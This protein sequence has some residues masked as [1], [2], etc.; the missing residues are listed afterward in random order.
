M[1]D[2]SF[3]VTLEADGA[4]VGERRIGGIRKDK[5]MSFEWRPYHIGSHTLKVAVNPDKRMKEQNF[6]NNILE[7]DVVVVFPDLVPK[8]ITSDNIY[9]SATNK[10]TVTVSGTAECF[11]ISLVENG[12]VVGNTTNVTCYGKENVSVNWKPGSIGNH[13]ITAFVDSDDDIKETNEMNNNITKMFEVLLPDIVPEDITPE[14][15]YIDEVNTISVKVNGT[16]EGFNATLVADKMGV[17]RSGPLRY[18]IIPV[19]NGTFGTGETF[20]GNTTDSNLTYNITAQ[21]ANWSWKDIDTL[22]VS[23]ASNTSTGLIDS[24]DAW[25]VDYVAVVVNYTVN[26]TIVQTLELNANSVISSGNWSNENN[27]YITDD[28]YATATEITT[29][30]LGVADTEAVFGNI[31]SVVIKVEQYVVN[32]IIPSLKNDTIILKKTNLNT[33]NNSIKFEWL[34]TELGNYSLTVFLDSDNDVVETNETNNNLT[35]SVIVA[36]R[37]KLKL[38]SPKSGETWKG[39]RN[40]TWAATYEEPLLIDLFY[41]PD[42]RGYRWINITTN[43]TN[44]GSYAWDTEDV[45]DG[46]YMIKVVARAGV[47]T[48]EDKSDIFYIRNNDEWGSFHQNAGYAPCEAPDTNETAWVS[49]DIGAEGSSSLIVAKGKIFVYCT[50]WEGMYSD[51]TYL[52]ALDESTGEVLW[53]TKIAPREYGS[54]ATPA[55]KD[56]SVYVSS[57]KGIYRIDADTGD[58][59]WE[60]RFPTGKGSV[61]GGPAV[62]SRAVYVGDWDGCHYYGID[63]NNANEIWRFEVSG[64]AQSVPAVAYGNIYFGCYGGRDNRAYGVDAW[65]GKKIWNTSFPSTKH[66]CGSVTIAEGIVYFT[67][68]DFNGP[69]IFYALDAFNGTE[70]W[71]ASI[72]RTDSTPAY[73]P[74]RGY[75]YVAGGVTGYSAKEVSCFDAKT[76]KP[77]WKVPG[78][79]CPECPPLGSWTNSPI[80]TKDE[81]VFVGKECEKSEEMI[82]EYCGLYCLDAVTGEE[83]WHSEKGGSS[84]VVVNGFVY[85]IGE[86]K[87]IAFG[88]GTI[89]DLTVDANATD[90]RYV[91]GKKGNITAK[92]EN[93]GKSNVT[94]SFKV[95]LR[96]KG[97][98]TA[99]QTVQPPL[100]INNSR[101]VVFEWTPE[102][103][104]EHRL[105]VEVDPPPGNVTE[106][107]PWNNIANVT[108][109]VEDNKPDLIT[110]ITSVS[111]ST[112]YVGDEVT[113]EA[114]ITNIGYETSNL[115][116]VRFSVNDVEEDMTLTSLVNN[117]RFLYFT[118]NALNNGIYNLTVDANP[119]DSLTIKNEVTW[120]NNKDSRVVEVM[121]TPTPTPTLTPENPCYGPGSRGGYGGGSAGGIGEGSGIGEAGAGEAGGMQIPVNASDSADEK[122]KEVFGFPFGNASSGA[123]GGGGTLPL[124]LIALIVLTFALFY[125]GYYK[126]KRAY[127]GDKK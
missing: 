99:E 119:N 73:Y 34:T 37:I 55:Y 50:G 89:P 111:P 31:T 69:G 78:P 108:V 127:R 123:S 51:Y 16:A 8:A 62:T 45:P 125:F 71:S 98:V 5:T 57:G 25:S 64:K 66:V 81:K 122:K 116:Y 101:E 4:L 92:I 117:T 7:K 38:L 18:V 83:I 20:F 46:E 36:K 70:I 22:E 19:F 58:F 43:E 14:V 118:W 21:R 100:N 76:G 74:S 30:Q 97:D 65:S 12:T 52:V 11:N 10:I 29:M 91:V 3:N 1:T 95:E 54:W 80:V 109:F 110:S 121:P 24:G 96:H 79:Q 68:F 15:L 103:P 23:I 60:F 61:N 67:T 9:M 84:P 17:D 88:N 72:E 75:V 107:N 49:D 106:S 82:P 104:G 42:R 6:D 113:V 115:F 47:V 124:L 112:I 93:I 44:D 41:S 26:G 28:E 32:A 85:T 13:T 114:N 77:I 27:T 59:I 105:T 126:E 56:G 87:V 40:I 63:K 86:G 48:E 94:E 2:E 90:G 53:G 120:T 35:R 39:V 33:Y 102:N